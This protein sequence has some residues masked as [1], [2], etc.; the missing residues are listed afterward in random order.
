MLENKETLAVQPE[1]TTQTNTVENSNEPLR[2]PSEEAYHKHLEEQA[3]ASKFQREEMYKREISNSAEDRAA[4]FANSVLGEFG[5]FFRRVFGGSYVPQNDFSYTQKQQ[6][7]GYLYE[8]NN[9]DMSKKSHFTYLNYESVATEDEI[10]KRLEHLEQMRQYNRMF[11]IS[12]LCQAQ[13]RIR[14][15]GN[16]FSTTRLSG[17]MTRGHLAGILLSACLF[18]IRPRMSNVRKLAIGGF[19][20]HIG[21][22]IIQSSY[23]LYS[24]SRTNRIVSIY[25]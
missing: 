20:F 19:F 21:G 23:C 3:K 16:P 13:N 17:F 14:L 9:L 8:K 25:R 12:D 24:R 5:S 15:T 4:K 18:N 11:M 1:T 10:K 7:L 22:T 2:S 6:I